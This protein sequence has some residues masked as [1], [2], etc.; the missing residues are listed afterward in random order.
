MEVSGQIHA[1]ASLSA[2]I[3][4]IGGWV[5]AKGW[6]GNYGGEKNLLSLPGIELQVSSP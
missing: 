5:G 6:S 1:P 2:G 3:Y 4:Y